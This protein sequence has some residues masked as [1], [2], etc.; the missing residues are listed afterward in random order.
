MFIDISKWNGVF[1]WNK[2]LAAGVKGAYI[3]V[4]ENLYLDSKFKQNSASCPLK[5]RGGY[6]FLGYG[7]GADGAKQAEFAVNSMRGWAYNLPLALD[8]EPGSYDKP[9][10]LAEV[11]KIARAFVDRY[12]ALTGHK[13]VIYVSSNR[14][15][16]MKDFTDCPLWVA[17]YTLADAPTVYNWTS[18]VLWQYSS[19]GAG[20]VY[21]NEIG[22]KYIDLNRKGKPY[23]EWAIDAAFEAPVAEVG[24]FWAQCTASRLIVR[25]TP[26]GV[27][28]TKRLLLGDT[29][30][31]TAVQGDWYKVTEGWV[32][33]LYMARITEPVEPEPEPEPELTDAEKLARLWDAHKELH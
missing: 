31:V 27:D 19:E 21:G 1:D 12:L 3:K 10:V 26:G 5:W 24:T 29:R 17:H 28:T 2:A 15:Q 14:T 30:Q 9:F 22:N 7:T 18:Y 4:S 6:H 13:P 25:E 32:S 8:I 23:S 20:A 11:L 16:Y 33:S